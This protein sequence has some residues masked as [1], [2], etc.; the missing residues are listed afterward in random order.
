MLVKY[1]ERKEESLKGENLED[2]GHTSIQGIGLSLWDGVRD[3]D[4]VIDLE[5]SDGYVFM[6]KNAGRVRLA[7]ITR[8]KIKESQGAGC[9]I[10]FAGT[11]KQSKAPG[12]A[13]S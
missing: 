6:G 12:G 3:G 4:M 1:E 13:N 11:K 9:E 2:M 5:G 7:K 10:S 8:A